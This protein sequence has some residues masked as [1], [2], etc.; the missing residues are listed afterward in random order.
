M[1]SFTDDNFTF[2]N[3][4]VLELGF[5]SKLNGSAANLYAVLA[6]CR[7]WVT[8]ECSPRRKTILD[9]CGMTPPTYRK[10]LKNLGDAGLAEV[11]KEY[12]SKEQTGREY[13]LI[14]DYKEALEKSCFEIDDLLVEAWLNRTKNL[15]EKIAILD[16]LIDNGV[17]RELKGTTQRL[18]LTLSKFRN[19]DDNTC[20]PGKKLIRKISKLSNDGYSAGN[21][22]LLELGLIRIIEE[23]TTDESTMRLFAAT[24]SQM[25]SFADHYKREAKKL[26]IEVADRGIIGVYGAKTKKK[27]EQGKKS[28]YP[29]KRIGL[30]TERKQK[31]AGKENS[32]PQGKKSDPNNTNQ[33][34]KLTIQS[35]LIDRLLKLYKSGN[36][37]RGHLADDN[38]IKNR[39]A[40]WLE[41]WDSS[42]LAEAFS[43]YRLVQLNGIEEC[44]L[45][46]KE[47]KQQHE[48]QA[49]KY[50]MENEKRA[51]EI[52]EFQE[53]M[54][55]SDFREKRQ[56]NITEALERIA[57]AKPP[58]PKIIF[59]KK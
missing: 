45:K 29:G 46:H 9:L 38:T 2:I 52:A 33:P 30:P 48:K 54:K 6:R 53:K 5:F 19:W 3:S 43:N 49:V 20:F 16:W 28:D 23:H 50:R 36:P 24:H 34:L 25:R 4:W 11:T 18:Y 32:A 37:K 58:E 14:R 7:N 21:K 1:G 22:E 57:N 27:R 39:I 31:K 40:V 44:E 51:A 55:S 12:D 15:D 42:Q 41:S 8:N 17:W 26:G 47:T 35:D 59:G 10:A 13:R 56:K